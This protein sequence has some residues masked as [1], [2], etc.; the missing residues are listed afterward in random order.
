WTVTVIGKG[1]KRRDVPLSARLALALRGRGAGWLFPGRIDGHLS[2]AYVSKR[3][4]AALGDA[5][6]GHQLRHRFASAAYR[7]ERDLR[8]VQVLLGHASVATTQLYT[9]VPDRALRRAV[10]AAAA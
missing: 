10:E 1:G 9:A 3:L 4:S 2:A 6:T 5:G 7:A 8:A